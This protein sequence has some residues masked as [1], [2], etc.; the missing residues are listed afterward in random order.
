MTAIDVISDVI[1]PWCDVGKRRPEQAVALAGRGDVG[2]RW[3]PFQ[4]NPQMPK[5][6]MNRK[7]YHTAKF[8]SW[9]R[10]LALAL[11]DCL[12]AADEDVVEAL[13]RWEPAQLNYGEQLRVHGQRF[14]NRSQ[15]N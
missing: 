6:G 15:L 1:C 7:E 2:I 8:G 11:V 14:G 9:E 12:T 10:S 5:A 4:L 3:H 13:R